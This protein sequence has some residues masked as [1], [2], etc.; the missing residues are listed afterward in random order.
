MQT[1]FTQRWHTILLVYM[2]EFTVKCPVKC[3]AHGNMSL[4]K[5]VLRKPVLIGPLESDI[6]E[7]RDMSEKATENKVYPLEGL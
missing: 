2:V 1:S 5:N 3:T 7:V 4:V 6:V